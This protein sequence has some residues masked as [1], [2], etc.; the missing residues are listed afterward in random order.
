MF[1]NLVDRA[2][3]EGAFVPTAIE[4]LSIGTLAKGPD[5]GFEIKFGGK[6]TNAIQ[7]RLRLNPLA[8]PLKD[9]IAG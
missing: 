4:G 2:I 8:L 6:I 1:D 7:E 9:F 3:V 5:T